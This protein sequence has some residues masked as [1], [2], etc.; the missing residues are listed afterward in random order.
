MCVL[1]EDFGRHIFGTQVTS[2]FD[3]LNSITISIA[4]A[5]LSSSSRTWKAINR[6]LHIMKDGS[7]ASSKLRLRLSRLPTTAVKTPFEIFLGRGYFK[8]TNA[9]KER[10][11]A[12]GSEGLPEESDTSSSLFETGKANSSQAKCT[13]ARVQAPFEG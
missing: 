9:Q 7:C 1:C 13:T 8:R 5:G 4:C 11:L 12:A 10:S 3:V 6:Y 2:T